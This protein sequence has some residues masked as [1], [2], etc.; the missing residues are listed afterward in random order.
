MTRVHEDPRVTLPHT[1]AAWAAIVDL[2]TR[3]DHRLAAADVR[4]TIGGEPTFVSIDN[5]VDEEWTTAADGPHKRERASALA[6]AHGKG[7]IHRDLKPDNV[8]L[9]S[10]SAV[11]G[12]VRAKLLDFG[13]ARL[14][15]A[16]EELTAAQAALGTLSY[17]A[18]EVLN[19]QPADARA[20]HHHAVC[21]GALSGHTCGPSRPLA[22]RAPRSARTSP[23]R[24]SRQRTRC[25]SPAGVRRCAHRRPSRPRCP[26]G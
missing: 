21:A 12:G 24:R 17:M 2:G 18:P 19:G 22:D 7:I 5:Q 3:V 14:T 4:L 25:G 8:M 23:R 9:V 20:D 15:Q 1:D 26:T 16:T 10:D 6:A 13:I 11:P